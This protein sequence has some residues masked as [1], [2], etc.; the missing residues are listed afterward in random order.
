MSLWFTREASL[1]ALETTLS[2]EAACLEDAFR[3][4][5]YSAERMERIRPVTPF[6]RATCLAIVKARN[7]AHGCYSL[8]LD[9]HSQESGALGRPLI[10][11]IELLVYILEDPAR[12]EEVLDGKLPSPGKRAKA[13]DGFA[14][15]PRDHWSQHASHVNLSPESVAHL[16]SEN[17]EIRVRQ[18]FDC[19]FLRYNMS[20]I[21]SILIWAADQA[22]RCIDHTFGGIEDGVFRWCEAVN[23]RGTA[24]FGLDSR[25]NPDSAQMVSSIEG[26]I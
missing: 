15:G 8:A 17:G 13:I 4:L 7:L 6:S 14:K 2:E 3:I 20:I 9:G 16:I 19:A 23:R 22:L 26:A 24:C 10:E 1:K 5:A 25:E 21:F 12:A 18:E 11:S